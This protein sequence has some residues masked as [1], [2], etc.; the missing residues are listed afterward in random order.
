MPGRVLL[1]LRGLVLPAAGSPLGAALGPAYELTARAL[2]GY[3]TRG[4]AARAYAR[5]SLGTRDTAPGH[6]DLDLA[7]VTATHAGRARVER[8]WKHLRAPGL[9]DMAV[10]ESADLR[11]AVSASLL[12]S[13]RALQPGIPGPRDDAGLRLRPGVPAPLW[14]WRPLGRGPD[15]L[16]PRAV[17]GPQER[18]VAAWLEL[19]FVWRVALAACAAPSHPHVPRLGLK[20]AA[21]PARVWLWLAHGEEPRTRRE[22]LARAAELLPEEAENLRAAPATTATGLT[23]LASGMAVLARVSERIAALVGEAAEKED[24]RRVRLVGEVDPGAPP[25]VDWHALAFAPHLEETFAPSV[26]MGWDPADVATAGRVAADGHHAA[27]RAGPI[28]V[29]AGGGWA[30][31]VQCAA[32]DPVSFALI[33]GDDHAAFPELAG[34]SA[35]DWARRAVAEHAGWLAH[36]DRGLPPLKTLTRL[37]AAARAARFAESLAGPEPELPMTAEAVAGTLHGGLGVEALHEAR[38]RRRG[39]AVRGSCVG[40]LREAIAALPAYSR[41]TPARAAP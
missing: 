20:L 2:G 7:V 23:A 37:L 12:T 4:I 18:R 6:S 36:K 32:T 28:M 19:Q 11:D 9:V 41:R 38:Q 27:T 3:L 29:L 33:A 15:L 30:R 13:V 25:L 40:A 5:G 17:P 24:H 14:D 21:D 1:R 39:A 22:A 8:R 34:W 10:Y 31:P 16:P 35:S 26:R